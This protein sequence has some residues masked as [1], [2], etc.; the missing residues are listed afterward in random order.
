[1]KK[2]PTMT[3]RK[4]TKRKRIAIIMQALSVTRRISLN[5]E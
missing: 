3:R 1:M 4:S 2:S 5:R